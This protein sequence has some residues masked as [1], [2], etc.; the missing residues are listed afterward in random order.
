MYLMRELIEDITFNEIGVIFSNRDHSTV[1][2]ACKRVEKKI[3]KEKEYQI[4][5]EKIKQK[6]GTI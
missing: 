2:K 4:A 3:K 6:L 1:M 5:I